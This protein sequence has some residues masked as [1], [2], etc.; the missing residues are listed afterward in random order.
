MAAIEE[1]PQKDWRDEC[2]RPA[3]D[4]RVQTA[5]STFLFYYP[6]LNK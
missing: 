1:T 4:T 6:P 2:V 5:V 3:K